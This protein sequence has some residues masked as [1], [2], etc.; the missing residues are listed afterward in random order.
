MWWSQG[1]LLMVGCIIKIENLPT[2]TPDQNWYAHAIQHSG[3]ALKHPSDIEFEQFL[4][5]FFVIENWKVA[6]NKV[7]PEENW[8]VEIQKFLW[9][10]KVQPKILDATQAWPPM[11]SLSTGNDVIT[12]GLILA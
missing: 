3:F 7:S 10:M 4:I 1:L 5:D 9:Q 11:T 6:L 8:M 12:N 2:K